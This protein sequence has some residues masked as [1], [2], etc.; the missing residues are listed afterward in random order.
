[1]ES[2]A[3]IIAAWPSPEAFIEDHEID[4]AKFAVWKHRSGIPSTHWP[5]TIRGAA[6]RRLKGITLDLLAA[7]ARKRAAKSRRRAA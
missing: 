6:R 4:A 5:L 7:L 1:M 3:D 2:F